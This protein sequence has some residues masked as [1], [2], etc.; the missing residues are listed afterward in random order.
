MKTSLSVIVPAYNEEKLIVRT[1]ESVPD[2]IDKIVVIDDCSVD[3]TVQIVTA[4]LRW[5]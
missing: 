3:Q 4:K 2:F 5:F 1:I